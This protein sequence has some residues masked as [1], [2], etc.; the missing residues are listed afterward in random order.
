MATCQLAVIIDDPNKKYSNGEQV[1]GTVV[2]TADSDVRCKGLRVTSYWSTHGRGNTTRGES[3][4]AILFEGEWFAG[5]EYR[6]PFNLTTA[7]WP[8]TH[9]GNLLNISHFVEAQAKLPWKIDPKGVAEYVVVAIDAP[10]NAAPILNQKKNSWLSLIFGA[11]ALIVLLLFL[12][13][14]LLL[15]P[16]IAIIGVCVWLVKIVIPGRITGK[17][18]F[19]TEPAVVLAGEALSGS[20]EF[21]PK[22]TSPI[23]RIVWTVK[24]TEKCV[25]G[26][27]TKQTTHTHELISKEHVLAVAGTLKAGDLQRFDLQ[28]MIPTNAPPTMKLTNNEILWSSEFRVD[29][30]NWPDWVKEIPFVVKPSKVANFDSASLP[31][32]EEYEPTAEEE[33]WLTEVLRQVAQ[34]EE[35]P[36]RLQDVLDAI[37]QQT[38]H[39]TL[40]LQDEC[41]DHIPLEID[42]D[43]EWLLAVDTFRNVRIALFVP[44][45]ESPDALPWTKDW[46]GEVSIVGFEPISG[47]VLMKII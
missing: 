33:K 7:I 11:I 42:T 1:S 5:K 9:Y 36:D 38:F 16:I 39:V 45:D 13:L 41:E 44:S 25:S 20:C 31:N 3:D 15:L 4:E 37:G 43:G 6:Y 22:T 47:L 23:N 32:E 10:D 30:P 18:S 8:P 19:V 12:P 17:V 27:G 24:C 35:D 21:T 28:Y 26:S 2:V 46:K 29:I 14:L 34:S 40:D